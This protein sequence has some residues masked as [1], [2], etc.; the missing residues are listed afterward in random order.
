MVVQ[1]MQ[2]I[3]EPSVKPHH[4]TGQE[5]PIGTLYQDTI[6]LDISQD[7]SIILVCVLVAQLDRVLASEA[8]G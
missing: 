6:L 3:F 8:K 5:C 2:R 4:F 1:K 7:F